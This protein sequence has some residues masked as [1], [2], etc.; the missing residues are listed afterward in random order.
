M[1]HLGSCDRLEEEKQTKYSEPG[2]DH[3]ALFTIG[4]QHS[5]QVREVLQAPGQ[6]AELSGKCQLER[7]DKHGPRDDRWKLQREDGGCY[8]RYHTGKGT[9][10][11][12][13]S[14]DWVQI[15]WIGLLRV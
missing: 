11:R 13:K 12:D 8:C 9:P 15:D 14:G 10:R 1:P 4:A 2:T 3:L 6:A 7:E 5:Q